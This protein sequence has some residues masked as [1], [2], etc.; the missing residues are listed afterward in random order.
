MF[1]VVDL[2]LRHNGFSDRCVHITLERLPYAVIRCFILVSSI[3]DFMALT[4]L[5]YLCMM[6][7]SSAIL[8]G[9]MADLFVRLRFFCLIP[10]K[11]LFHNRFIFFAHPFFQRYIS[12]MLVSPPT[13]MSSRY[14]LSCANAITFRS[15][16][17][18][19]RFCVSPLLDVLWVSEPH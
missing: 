11:S 3:L 4:I 9:Q 10:S 5:L 6:T 1:R 19:L 12:V 15:P 2:S 16:S 14:D 13:I 8:P 18:S 7:I 17:N